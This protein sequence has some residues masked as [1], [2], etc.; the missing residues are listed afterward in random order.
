MDLKKVCAFLA[1]AFLV[2]D[3][4]L[5]VLCIHSHN[6]LLYLSNDMVENAVTFIR[7][8]NTSV[9]PAVIKRKIPDNAIYTFQ[10]ENATLAFGVASKLSDAFFSGMPVSFVETPDG[11][12][13]TIGK[14]AEAV[15]SLRVY[16]DSFRFEYAK[17]GFRRDSLALSPDAFS[18]AAP[19]LTE[20]QKKAADTFL[21]SLNSVKNARSAYTLCGV[22]NV[23]GGVY[24]SFSQ[25]VY[26]DYPI[27]DMFVNV[28]ISDSDGV[29]YACGNRIFAAFSLLQRHAYER[30]QCACFFGFCRSGKHS[31]RAYRLC[32]PVY[33]KRHALPDSGL[34]DR[35]S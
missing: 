27:S 25:N 17:T 5:L 33:R 20:E 28:Y 11:V 1:A 16:N 10:T 26:A 35:I 13:Y 9:E 6:N 31:L 8:Q 21:E 12:S 24:A 18:G 19:T 32:T 2:V 4:F 30:Y 29:A 7:S 22:M 15:A 23:D 14:S 3:V 34:G